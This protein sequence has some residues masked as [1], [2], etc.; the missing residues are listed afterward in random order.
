MSAGLQYR[1]LSENGSLKGIGSFADSV[2]AGSL[3]DSESFADSF[4]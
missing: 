3:Q 2:Q 4:Y 1:S